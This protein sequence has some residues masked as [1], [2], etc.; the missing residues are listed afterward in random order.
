MKKPKNK[1]KTQ[2]KKK[3]KANK[4]RKKQHRRKILGFSH[5]KT[6]FTK[7]FKLVGGLFFLFFFIFLFLFKSIPIFFSKYLDLPISSN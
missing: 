4:T 7:S 3:K 1:E 6:L 5:F 2:K